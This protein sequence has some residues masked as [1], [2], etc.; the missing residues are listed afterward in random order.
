MTKT[1][2]TLTEKGS[3]SCE[4]CTK[5]CEGWLTAEIHGELMY[6]GKP[7]QNCNPGIGCTDYSNRPENPCKTYMCFWRSDDAVPVQFKP[8][9]VNS[10]I[11]SGE[12]DGM[13]YLSLFEAGEK[14]RPE[15]VSW[16]TS[17]A[18]ANGINAEWEILGQVHYS[19]STDF[20]ESISKHNNQREDN[21]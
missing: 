19:G 7:C 15:I 10:I 1:A 8:S 2:L 4:G 18:S 16:F 21:N 17:F 20:I 11:S 12:M 9:D 13:P 3:R 5:C 14:M 6:P